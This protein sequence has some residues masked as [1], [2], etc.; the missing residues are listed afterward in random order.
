M[1]GR[2]TRQKG[3]DSPR[4]PATTAASSSSRPWS[5]HQRD[6]FAR[7]EGKG[8][9]D[10]RQHDARQREQ[11]VDV[12]IDQPGAEPALHPEH[13]HIDQARHHR[14]HREGQ[15]DQ[16]DQEGLAGKIELGDRPGRGDAEHGVER[17]RDGGGD[18]RQAHRRQACRAR[19]SARRT[20]PTP[21]ANASL[22]T[23]TSGSTRNSATKPGCAKQRLSASAQRTGGIVGG[24]SGIRG[25]IVC[26]SAFRR[27][28]LQ[29]VQRQQH[30][31]GLPPA[32]P[33]RWRPRRA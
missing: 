8:D 6:Q 9:E 30:H 5:G 7:H 10:G 23:I 16:G 2:V 11:D 31:E 3:A 21:S 13:Q 27:P 29:A 33:R 26:S 19:R 28:G 24:R 12:M 18:Q 15:V 32:S 17:H 22:N 25:A 1:L 20:A 4:R 14:R